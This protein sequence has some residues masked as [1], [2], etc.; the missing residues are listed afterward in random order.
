MRIFLTAVMILTL[1]VS[2]FASSPRFIT[3]GTAYLT[4]EEPIFSVRYGL[5]QEIPFLSTEQ[6]VMYSLTLA[7]Y[8]GGGYLKGGDQEFAFF[9]VRPTGKGLR[10]FFLIGG[11]VTRLEKPE[12]PIT[13]FQAST[14]F[15]VYLE[16]S[17]QTAVALAYKSKSSE[18]QKAATIGL[19]LTTTIF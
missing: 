15:G 18:D 7:K 3:G 14:G 13:Y 5:S 10:V 1:S 12:G 17:K 6:S 4:E 2:A 11:D 9:P 8:G 16:I 19:F